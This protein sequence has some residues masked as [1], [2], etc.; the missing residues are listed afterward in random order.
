MNLIVK[1]ESMPNVWK[2]NDIGKG[3]KGLFQLNY[4]CELMESLYQLLPEATDKIFTFSFTYGLNCTFL[5][6]F[7]YTLG[8]C[9]IARKYK[10]LIYFGR[11]LLVYVHKK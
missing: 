1:F 8:Y 9:W 10:F 6:H 3:N 5:L 7:I 2:Y 11:A 4:Q